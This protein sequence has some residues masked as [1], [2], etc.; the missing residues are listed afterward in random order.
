MFN[1]PTNDDFMA[2]MNAIEKSTAVIEFAP[3]GT[4]ITANE[5]FLKTMGYSL[6]EIQGK[7]H[8]IFVYPEDSKLQSYQDFWAK[9]RSGQYDAGEYRRLAKDGHE[10]WI[11]ASYN[12]VF[13]KKGDLYKILK[14]ATDVTK[15]KLEDAETKGQL[16]AINKAQAIIEFNIDGTISNA[17]ENFLNA[18]GYSLSEIVGK[19][20][21]IF[22]SNEEAK[23]QAYADFW[24]KLRRGEF[25]AK[26]YK[27]YGKNGREVWIQASYNPILDMSGKTFKII[28]FAT[29][30]T[31]DKLRNADVSGQID[32]INKAQA[33]IHFNLDGTVISA[34]QNFLSL[35][36][37]KE[38]EIKDRHHSLFVEK[39]YATSDDYKN[40]WAS[41]RSGITDSRVFK[42]ITK[43][44][45]EVWIQ[46]SYSPILDMNKKP[47]KVVK[48]AT[49]VTG[50]INL[51][52][53]TGKNVQSVV[54]AT[55]KLTSSIDEIT[56]NM[57]LSQE[58]TNNIVD[59]ANI[60]GEAST[61]LV[62][63][64]QEMEKI[65]GLIRGIAEKV[66]LLALNAT[67]EAARA[68]EA[69]KG[70]SV[71]A[72]EVKNLA[73]QTAKATDDIAREILQ[74]QSISGEVANTVKDII[75]ASSSVSHYVESVAKAIEEQSLITNE[76]S[77]SSQDTADA[78]AMISESIKQKSN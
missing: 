52:D 3:D 24:A 57:S 75:S 36:E 62:S 67:I 77:K 7:H 5:N 63:T 72:T 49:D 18:M 1:K 35:M 41:L 17:N 46:A 33:V 60:S 71:V 69:G 76:I 50:I 15:R 59:R 30:L 14:I 9:L 23:S 70:F 28:K 51:T 73:G 66:N 11:Q 56:R 64:T 43:S 37:Y 19:H 13:N 53:S 26:E 8:R 27:R 74:V 44:G 48:F 54:S 47:Y 68:G 58:A 32:A 16:T 78:V 39:D 20:H 61:K 25:E 45:K 2:K 10:I 34:N 29:D 22:V 4:I 65:V 21:K 40:F 31:A 38:N 6:S 55:S 42:R 12:P